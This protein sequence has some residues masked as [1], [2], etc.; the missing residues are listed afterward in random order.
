MFFLRACNSKPGVVYESEGRVMINHINSIR[1]HCNIASGAYLNGQ[2]TH[3]IHEFYPE[4]PPGYKIIMVP[5][6]IIYF[7]VNVRTLNVVSVTF[8][9]QDGNNVSFNGEVVTLRLHI[10]KVTK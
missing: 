10:K 8:K 2:P 6:N 9:D 7:P 1:V 4:V 3:A 5:S